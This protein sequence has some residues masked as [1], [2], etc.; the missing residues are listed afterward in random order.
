MQKKHW[1]K[2]HTYLS[3]FFLPMCLIYVL[4]GVG[5]IFDLKDSAGAKTQS[6]ALV[7]EL[8]EGDLGDLKVVESAIL[9]TLKESNLKIPSNTALRAQKGNLTMGG[10]KY[11][12]TLQKGKD[13]R[14]EVKTMERSIYGVLVLM[15]KAKGAAHF[16]ALAICFAISLTLFYLS[17]LIVTSFC[18]KNRKS[19]F[20]TLGVG[21][22]VTAMAVFLSV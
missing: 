1:M 19:A 18:K 16:N 5:Y 10:I 4:T 17:G 14:F 20:A 6:V 12:V 11:S 8:N 2:I 3:L 13:G 21:F 22:A 15:H 7:G 9:T